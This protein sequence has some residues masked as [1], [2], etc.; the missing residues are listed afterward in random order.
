MTQPRLSTATSGKAGGTE[1]RRETKPVRRFIYTLTAATAAALTIAGASAASAAPKVTPST[2]GSTVATLKT[3]GE[4]ATGRDFRFAQATIQVPDQFAGFQAPMEYVALESGD[5]DA[6]AGIISCFIAH[7]ISSSFHCAPG[8][9]WAA[10]AGTFNNDL[11]SP[12][13][14]F[15]ALPGVNEGDGVF[16][17]VYDNAAGNSLHFVI[18]TPG[19][20]GL[21]PIPSKTYYFTSPDQGGVYNEAVALDDWTFAPTPHQA[22]I[23]HEVNTFSEG[24]FTTARGNQGSF[25]GPWTLSPVILTSNGL[26]PSAGT[27]VVS[28]T[29]LTTTAPEFKGLAGNTFSIEWG[30][31]A[32]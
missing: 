31:N 12:A 9:S 16:F 17:S 29:S 4:Q 30:G 5:S 2:T 10:F 20:G 8:E 21:N 6:G 24:R 3:A 27:T 19:V 22:L 11:T 28:P 23:G 1:H 15:K 32:N 25:Q 14:S 13:F 7:A 18:T 26:L